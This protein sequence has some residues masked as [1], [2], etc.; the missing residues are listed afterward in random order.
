MHDVQSFRRA[1]EHVHERA[2][3][4]ELVDGAVHALEPFAGRLRGG[5]A[6]EQ[7]EYEQRRGGNRQGL[8]HRLLQ[9]FLWNGFRDGCFGDG[10]A[11]GLDGTTED[12]RVD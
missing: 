8:P 2:A 1:V 12:I 5:I 3:V 4:V 9:A 11:G 6:A 10:L 7:Y